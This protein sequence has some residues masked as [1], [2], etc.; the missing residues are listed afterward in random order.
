MKIEPLGVSKIGFAGLAISRPFR[1][2]GNYYLVDML[3]GVGNNAY[4]RKARLLFI[5]SWQGATRNISIDR[6]IFFYP[7]KK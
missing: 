2:F 1:N 3:R 5:H 4:M 6:L 7:A